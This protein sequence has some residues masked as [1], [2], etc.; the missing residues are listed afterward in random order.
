MTKKWL[1]TKTVL[2]TLNVEPFVIQTTFVN[3]VPYKSREP[4]YH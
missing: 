1:Q 3:L 4:D 2:V